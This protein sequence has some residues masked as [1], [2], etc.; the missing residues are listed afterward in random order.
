MARSP[1]RPGAQLVVTDGSQ[2]VMNPQADIPVFLA[3]CNHEEA[4]TRM[5]LHV[6]HAA[7]EGHQKILIRTVDTDVVVLALMVIQ[8]VV[9]I[10]ELWI[11][12]GVNKNFRYFTIHEIAATLGP[13]KTL[14]LPIFHAFTGCDTV[15]SFAGHG[16]KTAWS[17]WASF[18]E[19]T[20][21]L[22][23]ISSAPPHVPDE[24]M[25]VIE[26]FV[27]LMYD[28]TSPCTDID[29]ARKNIFAKRSTAE[30]IPPSHAA[31]QQHIKRAVYQDGFI[32]SQTLTPNP[33]LPSPTDWGWIKS[34][35]LY[36]P[37]WTALPE[38]SKT[39]YELKSCGCKSECQYQCRCKR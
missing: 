1:L 15:S 29:I 36:E 32:W 6:A 11:A 13:N 23:A 33:T 20:D 37:Y 21:A 16:K 10:D 24:A 19:L 30:R 9:E 17:V 39:C 12:F 25:Q 14:V 18:P 5:F 34:D 28:R 31:L 2:V 3:L 26:R 27:I 35:G 38:A 7:S 8:K 22:L 4:D